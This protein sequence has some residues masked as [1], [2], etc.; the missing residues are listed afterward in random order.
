[1]RT[2][3]K[4]LRLGASVLAG[5]A[6]AASPSLAR[7]QVTLLTVVEL[8]Q[9]NSSAVQLAEADVEKASAR[10]E[11]S[12]DVFIPSVSFGSGLPAFPEVGFTGALPTLYDATI[13][14]MAFSMPMI[15]YAQAARAGLTAAEL[16]LKDA[17]EQVTLDASRAYIELDTVDRELEAARQQEADAR[18]LVAIEQQRTE[19]GVDPM[20]VLLQAQLTAAQ[21]KLNR[22]HL[23]TRAATLSKQLAGLTGLPAASITLD[24]AS[25]PAIPAIAADDPPRATPGLDSARMLAHSKAVAARG[26][27]E[28]RW[29]P[30]FSFG[31]LYDR[32]TTVLNNIND[33]YRS[34]LPAN[35]F[36]SGFNIDLPIFN[37][38]YRARAR[39]SA[40]DALR[41]KIEAEQAQDQNNAQ[42]AELT[43]ELRELGTQ[44]E[45]AR[46][47]ARIAG[48]QLK[49][50]QSQLQLGAGSGSS[51]Q[52]QLS[53]T[54]EQKALINEQQKYEDALDAQLKLNEAR[55]NLLRALGHMQDWLNELHGK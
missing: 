46:L 3:G 20:L 29:M 15:R 36:S 2:G 22:Q 5:L 31:V 10:L 53:P 18:R 33:Y 24:H 7:A 41:A 47:K 4:P 52:P 37:A 49:S 38:G 19:A 35:N 44:A 39:E 9:R 45:I 25:I 55:L 11:E 14:S 50:V 30:E 54:D 32:N 34:Y 8:A 12:H 1:M 48:E 28:R 17:R 27:R 23:E 6:L 51:A 13:Q 42:I 21:L 43:A 26:D 40:A 16:S